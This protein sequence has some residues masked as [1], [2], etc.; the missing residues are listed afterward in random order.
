M[1]EFRI[2]LQNEVMKGLSTSF[3]GLPGRLKSFVVS[4]RE[5]TGCL[6]G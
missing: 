5:P 2:S 4:P 1:A 6:E 3:K